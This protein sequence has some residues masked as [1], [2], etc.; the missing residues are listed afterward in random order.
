MHH[1]NRL[2]SGRLRQL[3]CSEAGDCYITIDGPWHKARA[4]AAHVRGVDQSP[5]PGDGTRLRSGFSLVLSSVVSGCCSL[6]LCDAACLCTEFIYLWQR[7]SLPQPSPPL[8]L[9]PV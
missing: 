7:V 3:R 2:S 6:G 9:W 4:G 8:F 1:L 5:D